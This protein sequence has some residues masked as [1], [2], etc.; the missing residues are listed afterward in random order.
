MGGAPSFQQKL[1]E[2][3]AKLDALNPGGPPPSSLNEVIAR[4]EEM[5]WAPAT[6]RNRIFEY[7]QALRLKAGDQEALFRAYL[8]TVDMVR[9]QRYSTEEAQEMIAH[10]RA[11]L[12]LS[13][14]RFGERAPDLPYL[15]ASLF[16]FRTT[17]EGI[18]L[19]YC[20]RTHSW[21]VQLMLHKC[22]KKV[23]DV[24]VSLPWEFVARVLRAHIPQHAEGYLQRIAESSGM[25]LAH[26]LKAY[27]GREMEIFFRGRLKWPRVM[28]AAALNK[29]GGP[30]AVAEAMGHASMRT[31]KAY[32]SVPPGCFGL[33]PAI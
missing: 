28:T 7:R 1:E 14:A 17:S 24:V 21:R 5:G 32:L 9:T 10:S 26:P 20:A 22:A 25:D 27:T 11:L 18:S 16:G 2:K 3:I 31:Q 4:V 8:R 29:F 15:A 19:G 12:R 6:R 30:Q 13:T 33:L 23:G